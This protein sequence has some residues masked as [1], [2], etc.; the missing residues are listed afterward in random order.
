[1]LTFYSVED[2]ADTVFVKFFHCLSFSSINIRVSFYY[3]ANKICINFKKS[4]I[5]L[6]LKL[7]VK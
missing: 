3:T 4:T 7:A 1:M 5:L 6:S 2:L